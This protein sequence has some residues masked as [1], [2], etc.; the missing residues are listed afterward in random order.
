MNF[1]MSVRTTRL[2]SVAAINMITV[3]FAAAS[4][5]QVLGNSCPPPSRP[6]YLQCQVDVPA[7]LRSNSPLPIVPENLKDARESAVVATRLQ[8]VV[9]TTGR[10]DMS[11]VKIV[12]PSDGADPLRL[13]SSLP[14]MRFEPAQRGSTLVRVQL[15]E[16]MVFVV[17]PGDLPPM[18][19]RRDTT[20]L[21][22]PR[23]I[24]G[25]PLPDSAGAAA[26]KVLDVM[27]A[28]SAAV[29]HSL[30]NSVDNVNSTMTAC[31][32]FSIRNQ[33]V[34]PDSQMSKSMSTQKVNIVAG[35]KCPPTYASMVYNPRM[36]RPPAGYVDPYRF[37]FQKVQLWSADQIHFEMLREHGMG[38]LPSSCSARR[39]NGRWTASCRNGLYSFS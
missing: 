11:T 26:L 10:I 37:S 21:G 33:R 18:P 20:A 32:V 35:T 4:Y 19:V 3:S 29:L 34:V 39:T 28:Q 23:S 8:F 5:A 13:R 22:I 38:R 1:G 27:E 25:Q 36:P 6:P 16:W 12:E 2:T 7:T 9:D 31:V 30:D 17:T 14:R 24:I 15:D